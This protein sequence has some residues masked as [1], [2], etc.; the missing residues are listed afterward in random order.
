MAE[1]LLRQADNKVFIVGIAQESTLQK[2]DFPNKNGNGTYVAI[3][4]DITVKTGEEESHVVSYFAKELTAKGEP[5]KNF[6]ALTTIMNEIVTVADVAQGL[7]EGEPTRLQCQGELSLNEYKGNDGEIKSFVKIQGKFSPQRYKG[8]NFEADIKATFDIEGIIKSNKP[9]L[10][11]GEETGRLKVELYVPLYAGKVIPLDFITDVSVDN[12]GVEYLQENFVPRSSVNIYGN[13]INKSKKIE[14]IVESAFG[15]NKTETT[16]ERTR[17]FA[18][19]GG[20][21]YE[22]GVHEKQIF[23]VSLLKEALAIRERDLATLKEKEVNKPQ[24]Q[25]DKG[26]GNGS[27]NTAPQNKPTEDDGLGD[28]FGED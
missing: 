10:V 24:E 2:K 17:E 19:D 14:R 26:F 25:K 21:L 3:S 11:D 20:T 18:F 15:K 8:E 6:K 13:I 22:E 16:Y 9:E 12:A 23:D 5:N 7:T 4:G 28:L 1:Q 27:A